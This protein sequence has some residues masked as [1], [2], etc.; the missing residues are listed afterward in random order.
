MAEKKDD[1]IGW[2]GF[3]NPPHYMNAP[4]FGWVLGWLL[5]LFAFLVLI[6]AISIIAKFTVSI[7]TGGLATKADDA[8]ALREL[9]TVILALFGAPFLVW[10]TM[11]ASKQAH[12]A[13]QGHITDRI[14]KA[15]EQIGTEKTV[16]SRNEAG[17]VSETTEPNLEVRIGG[18]L[19]LERIARDNLPDHVQ[20]M[21]I[22]C[23]YIRQAANDQ[24]RREPVP[25]YDGELYDGNGWQD[26]AWENRRPP[27][28][29]LRVAFN[30]I[31][32]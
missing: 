28:D 17:E 31:E 2:L 18:L 5:T 32:R 15:V 23:A 16:K 11:I 22:L 30:I 14:A 12:T 27:R 26:W 13:Q 29:D 10:R 20:V 25:E 24:I 7:F 1:L 9:G 6:L 8:R 3:A 4:R 19:S 21:E